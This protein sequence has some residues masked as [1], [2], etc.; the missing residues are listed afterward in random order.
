MKYFIYCRKSTDSEEKQILSIEA[1]LAELQE[2][3]AK[4]KLEIV[5]PTFVETKT[6]K[7]PG[8]KVFGEML[9][10]ICAGEASGILAWHPDRLARNSIDGGKIIYL[11]DTG[12]LLDLKF[13]T[14]WFDSTPQGKFM[15]NIA[16]GQSKYYI[17][18]LS[19][20]IKRG[21]RAKLR[22]GIWPNFAPLGY[23]N[24]PKTRAIDVDSEKAPLV[25]KAFELYATG[26]YTLKALAKVLEQAGLRSYKGNV[27]SVSCAQRMLQNPIY[28][29]V[30]SFN[31][32]IYDGTHEPIISKKL[33][34]SVQQVMNNRGKKKRKRKHEFA[35]SGLMRCGSCG[36]LITAETQKGHNYYRCTKKKQ[37]CNEK[38]LREEALVE[39]MESFIQKVSIPDD[40]A[41]NMLA[42]LDKEK[43]QAK[44]DGEIFVQNLHQQKS[45]VE[46]K[47]EKLL[48]LY[49]TGGALSI[50]E[51]QSKKQKLLN[52]KLDIEQKLRDFEQAGNNWLEPMKKMIFEA[53]Q[54]KILLSQGDNQQ[55]LTFLKNVGSNFILKG[56]KFDFE[57]KIG[58]RALAEGEPNSSFTNWRWVQDSNLQ[59]LAE[60]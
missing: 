57:P 14:F 5:G 26:E 40:W 53:K 47:I 31:G 34:D 22:K 42:E 15:M 10:R 11:L 32:E 13:P 27:L 33:F 51:Y 37:T 24:N 7:E 58:W 1:Q 18:N 29:G 25:K 19:E 60:R 50:E 30:F 23:S 8:R 2:F 45:E 46:Q 43:G 12:K 21:H 3:A 4:E 41:K 44:R 49:I 56:K 38:Y 55:I 54:A 6:A 36:C 16:F 52:E 28:Y 17:D 35:F 9:D 39:Q 59:T 20:N 48:D